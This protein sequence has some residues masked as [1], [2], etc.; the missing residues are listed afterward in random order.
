MIRI[1]YPYLL[2]SEP[3]CANRAR[4]LAAKSYEL[5]EFLVEQAVPPPAARRPPTIN[6][7]PLATPHS[8]LVTYHDSCHMCRLLGL[9]RQPRDLLQAAGYQLLEMAES[10]RCCGFGGLFSVH[11]PELSNAMTAEKLRQ[12][13]A[14]G[15]TILATADPGCLMQM[16]GL[17]LATAAPIQIEHI[18]TLLDQASGQQQK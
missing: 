10:D 17:A 16:R 14:T 1:E 4:Q 11:M 13:E 3:A 6:G 9:S 5:T 7:S 18:A 12:A 8:P 2:E 15:A